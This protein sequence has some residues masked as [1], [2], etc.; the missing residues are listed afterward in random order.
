MSSEKTV[1]DLLVDRTETLETEDIENLFIDE[2]TAYTNRLLDDQPY[3]LVG[4]RGVGKSMLL[5]YAELISEKNFSEKKIIAVYVTFENSL[6]MDRMKNIDESQFYQPF[7]QWT[8][9]KIIHATIIKC[10][11]LGLTSKIDGMLEEIFGRVNLSTMKNAMEHYVKILENTHIRNADE[12]RSQAESLLEQELGD[13]TKSVLDALDNPNSTKELFHKIIEDNQIERMVL[14]F[15]EAAH[16]LVPQ[17]QKDFFSIF[18]SLRSKTITCKAAVYPAVT[19]YGKDFDPA[20][21]GTKITIDRTENDKDYLDFFTNLLKRRIPEINPLWKK[22]TSD[23][24]ILDSL[25]YACSG[26]PRFLFHLVDIFDLSTRTSVSNTSIHTT[27]RKFVHDDL[28]AFHDNNGDRSKSIAKSAELGHKFIVGSVIPALS[29][30]NNNWREKSTP[31]FSI[32]FTV[33]SDIHSDIKPVLD[34][35]SYSGVISF[36]TE[37]KTGHDTTGHLYAVNISL[38]IAESVIKSDKKTGSSFITEIDLLS[39]ERFTQFTSSSDSIISMI[40]Q[41]SAHTGLSCSKCERKLDADANFCPFCGTPVAKEQSLYFE[42][43]KH[44]IDKL[45]FSERLKQR[46]RD[47]RDQSFE[48]VG[49]ILSATLSQVDDIYYIGTVRSRQIKG[50]ADEYVGS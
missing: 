24:E 44:K 7:R 9:A 29:S 1:H 15:D 20:H 4:S 13:N 22:L 41:L 49:D 3:L 10:E 33:A 23:P 16:A 19:H 11:K 30:Q 40:D 31:Q 43:L 2:K 6:V 38:A 48:T 26:N 21:D 45:R 35:L 28:W 27:C 8:F 12:L 36:R 18:K 14:L 47:H 39:R 32:F 42:L 17:Q 5:R 50:A 34:M 25:C 37:L 46:M